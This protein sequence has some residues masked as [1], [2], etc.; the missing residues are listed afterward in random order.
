MAYEDS[1]AKAVYGG[2]NRIVGEKT[3]Q[4]YLG[5][6]VAA[7]SGDANLSEIVISGVPFNGV[8]K[9]ESAVPTVGDIV[10]VLAAPGLPLI[11][12]GVYVGDVTL[13]P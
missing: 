4:W 5:N 8:P 13:Y 9:I 11:I 12:M 2:I 7:E 6:W 1:I 10:L 3:T